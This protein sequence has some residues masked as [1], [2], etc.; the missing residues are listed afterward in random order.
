VRL[1]LAHRRPVLAL[2]HRTATDA[3][4]KIKRAARH[5]SGK[6]KQRVLMPPLVTTLV[7]KLVCQSQAP[8]HY[9]QAWHS[10]WKKIIVAEP[11]ATGLRI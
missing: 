9:R 6:A 10:H 5:R 3:L 7:E 1:V 8:H 11:P 2:I 4:T